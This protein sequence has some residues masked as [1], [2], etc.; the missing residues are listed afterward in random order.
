M[1]KIEGVKF[2]RKELLRKCGANGADFTDWFLVEK[3]SERFNL[4]DTAYRDKVRNR[5]KDA[6]LN[7]YLLDLEY[8]KKK[9]T[10]ISR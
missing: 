2:I 8:W 5:Q 7:D 1:K 10:P 3:L 6:L 9:L 4:R